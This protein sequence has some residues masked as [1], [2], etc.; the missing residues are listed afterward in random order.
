MVRIT[1]HATWINLSPW[2]TMQGISGRSKDYPMISGW[3][4]IRSCICNCR[5]LGQ[6]RRNYEV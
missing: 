3:N 4:H 1:L 6:A 2:N 5:E